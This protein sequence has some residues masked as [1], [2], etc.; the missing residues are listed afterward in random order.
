MK[1]IYPKDLINIINK[2]NLNVYFP[3]EQRYNVNAA[4]LCIQ[5]I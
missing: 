2:N 4:M 3:N 1:N 5:G